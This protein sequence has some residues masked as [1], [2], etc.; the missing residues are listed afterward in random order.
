MVKHRLL[1]VFFLLISCHFTAI[2]MVLDYGEAAENIFRK[3][4]IN[5]TLITLTNLKI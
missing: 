3:L 1:T 4:Q 2:E 5:E